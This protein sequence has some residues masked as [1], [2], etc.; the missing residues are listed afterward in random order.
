M[1]T[2]VQTSQL[3]LFATSVCLVHWFGVVGMCIGKQPQ[4]CQLISVHLRWYSRH[5]E[6]NGQSRLTVKFDDIGYSLA[7][8]S[9]RTRT[10]TRSPIAHLQITR[11]SSQIH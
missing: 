10:R 7:R 5:V 3:S 8:T 9:E 4:D 2:K 11:D 1:N 6:T